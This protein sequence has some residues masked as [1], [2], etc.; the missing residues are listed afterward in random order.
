MA[1]GNGTT[2]PYDAAPLSKWIRPVAGLCGMIEGFLALI[3]A[4]IV[5]IS[6]L[7]N[8]NVAAVIATASLSTPGFA[9]TLWYFN[10]RNQEKSVPSMLSTLSSLVGVVG[11]ISNPKDNS[12]QPTATGAGGQTAPVESK[13]WQDKWSSSGGLPAPQPVNTNPQRIGIQVGA[14]QFEYDPITG[15]NVFDPIA[16]MN[17]VTAT[18]VLHNTDQTPSEVIQAF[19]ARS[20]IEG[21]AAP[22]KFTNTEALKNAIQF[23]FGLY[24]QGFA[25]KFGV[26]YST[27]VTNFASTGNSGCTTCTKTKC[28]HPTFEE[29]VDYMGP[30]YA[31]MLQEYRELQYAANYLQ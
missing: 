5:L 6:T 29:E 1:N 7:P 21:N 11:Q 16:F 25:K 9:F 31:R 23:V 14:M 22:W 19:V 13:P 10:I 15:Q 27:A 30:D 24:E 12:G 26:D 4:A 17:D 20:K 2:D 3:L 8:I 28:S 18:A